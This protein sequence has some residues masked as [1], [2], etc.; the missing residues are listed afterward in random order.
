MSGREN[1][2]TSSAAPK[3]VSTSAPTRSTAREEGRAD[4]LL[5]RRRPRARPRQLRPAP[6]Q[7]GAVLRP[8]AFTQY[9][10]LD[11][12]PR[13]ASSCGS[14]RRSPRQRLAAHPAAHQRQQ[15]IDKKIRSSRCRASK[16][17]RKATD[18]V[19]L[20]LRMQGNAF[21]GGFFRV[22]GLSWRKYGIDEARFR[23]VV[24][25]QYDKKFGRFGEAVVE[26]NMTV[27]TEGLRACTRRPDLY[28]ADRCPGHARPCGAPRWMLAL[29]CDPSGDSDTARRHR[30][31]RCA[32]APGAHRDLRPRVPRR[33]GLPPAGVGPGVGGR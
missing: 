8:E 28:G 20:Q 23:E 7:R 1:S 25:N 17:A 33:A 29:S 4:G 14:R 26:S 12:M 9:N 6:R 15:I 30:R 16:I 21:L 3:E 5:P 10:P 18:R 31:R 13:A 22:S 11:G 27:M 32:V 19:D 24:R 2:S